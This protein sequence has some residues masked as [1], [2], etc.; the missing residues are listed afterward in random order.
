M[1]I[2]NSAKK[3]LRQSE[4]K[5]VLNLRRTRAIKRIAKNMRE[6]VKEG[7]TEQAK[8]QLPLAQ[9]AIDKAQKRGVIKKNKGSRAKS[10]LAKLVKVSP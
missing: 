4:K 8:S 5:R 2:K 7:K 3:T 10:Q 9:K 1:P 6:L